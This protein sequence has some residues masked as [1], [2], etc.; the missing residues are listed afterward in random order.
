MSARPDTLY[1]QRFLKAG[2]FDPGALDGYHGPKTER[3]W[4][5][6]V[7]AGVMLRREMGAL[8][9]RTEATLAG[10]QVEMQRRCRAFMAKA[11]ELGEVKAISGARTYAEQAALYAQG[12]TAP[13][14][15]VTNAGPGSSNHNFGIAMDIAVFASGF[16]NGMKRPRS[17]QLEAVAVEMYQQLGPIGEAAGLEWGGRW[18]SPDL[19]HYQMP[20]GL[21]MAQIRRRFE[22]GERYF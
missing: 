16:Y 1:L 19:P 8:D 14:S 15:I 6:F 22:K 18:R 21:T 2:G 20:A 5:A 4:L 9:A 12:R 13:G 3:A 17:R 11:L 10:L 7:E